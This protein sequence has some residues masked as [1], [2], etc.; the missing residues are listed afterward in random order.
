MNLAK[1]LGLKKGTYLFSNCA[2]MPSK[3]KC[4]LLLMGPVRQK[5]DLLAAGIEHMIKVHKHKRSPKLYK[6]A[7]GM[8]E[9]V[10]VA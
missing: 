9:R 7:A 3:M 6:E 5:K 10:T 2:K 4:R 1:K 8:L